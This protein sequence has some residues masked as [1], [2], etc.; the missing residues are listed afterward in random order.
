MS[1]RAIGGHFFCYGTCYTCYNRRLTCYNASK[2]D[3]FGKPSLSASANPHCFFVARPTET[4]HMCGKAF[5]MV[6]MLALFRQA[7]DIG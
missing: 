7:K 5:G 1:R 3:S 4:A 2:L 6:V